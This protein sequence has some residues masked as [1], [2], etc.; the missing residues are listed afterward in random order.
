VSTATDARTG[1][2]TQADMKPVDAL[3]EPPAGRKGV[4]SVLTK[5]FELIEA[6]EV[7]AEFTVART[8]YLPIISIAGA[9]GVTNQRVLFAP[10][11]L[12]WLRADSI[13]WSN[14]THVK[15]TVVPWQNSM[16]WWRPGAYWTFETGRKSRRFFVDADD[17][18]ELSS[19]TREQGWSVEGQAT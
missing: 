1:Q 5:R 4:G 10:A 9:L 14:I 7:A 18:E 15:R 3:S 19:L 6:E 11:R 8:G 2:Q 16:I 13:P 17:D 12:P